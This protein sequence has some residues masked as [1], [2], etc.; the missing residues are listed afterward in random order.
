VSG[1]RSSSATATIGIADPQRGAYRG[2][3]APSPSGP[4]H[5]GS[6]VAAVG[7]YLEART[8]R[9]QWLL[10]IED[11]DPPRAR[12]GA[13]DAILRGLDRLQMHW[14]GE[15]LRQSERT[16]AYAEALGRL[17]AG[18]HLQSC[19]CSRSVLEELVQNRERAPGDEL[20]HP[21]QC[22]S[23]PLDG[24]GN[25]WRFRT[26][27]R[28]IRFLDR[29]Q[30]SRSDN[31]AR[32]CGNFVVQRRDGLFAYQL[33]VV[34]DDDAQQ[35]TDVVRGMDLLGS[36]A[37]QILLQESLGL[38]RP[39][40]MH[41]PLAVDASGVKLSKSGDAP[42]V[43][44]TDPTRLVVATL[45]FLRQQPPGELAQAP[46]EEVWAWARENWRPQRFEAVTSA[47]APTTSGNDAAMEYTA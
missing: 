14:D 19:G 2:R 22:P 40:Y 16:D 41:L 5:F 9:G 6:I 20:F 11:L 4:L 30:G 42:S 8:R 35:I 15:V 26:P 10:R 17:R 33:A 34:V 21:P 29:V 47:A 7:S 23:A 27:D 13:A 38:Q 28:E 25:A 46:L 3:F 24:T 39:T 12:P 31:V 36:T 44:N 18:G 32:S 43:E 37:R 45:E 1:E